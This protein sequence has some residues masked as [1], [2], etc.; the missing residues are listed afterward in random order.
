MSLEKK[1]G[2]Y[3]SRSFTERLRE[4]LKPE[5]AMRSKIE[6]AIRAI[7]MQAKRLETQAIR[8]R[9]KDRV[10]FN[11]VVDA[12]RKG[13]RAKATL[14]ANELAEI[15]KA[16]RAI[17]MARLA[18]EQISVRLSTIKDVGDVAV[19][20]APALV[21][22]RAV[23]QSVNEVLPQAD[24]ELADLSMLLDSILIDAGQFPGVTIDFRAANEEAEEILRQAE[25]KVEA[26][27]KE[28]FPA[29]PTAEGESLE[30]K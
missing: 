7:D 20:L 28:Q 19:T 9:D 14:Y 13:D 23:R 24:N 3:Q 1:W 22:M 18:L 27:L 26:E 25:A 12:L 29:I 21:V 16:I 5:R 6:N 30:L 15:R 8:L 17:N 11:R 10:F 2:G 4:A